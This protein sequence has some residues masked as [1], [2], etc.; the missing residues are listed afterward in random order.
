MKYKITTHRLRQGWPALTLAVLVALVY[1]PGRYGGYVFDDYPNIVENT[2]LHVTSLD[3]HAWIAAIFSFGVGILHRPLAMLTFAANYYFTGLDPVPMKLTNIAIH[4]VNA[5]LVLGLVRT[6]LATALPTLG[7]QRREWS[8]WFASAAWALHPINLM[9]VLFVVQRMESL[10]HTFVFAGLWLYL[11]G[12]QRQLDGKAGWTPIGLGILGGTALGVLVKESAVMLPLYAATVEICVLRF[13]NASGGGDRKLM[14]C[15]LLVLVLPAL[16]ALAWLL[17][18]AL[19]PTAYSTRDFTL[20]ERLLTEGRVVMDYLR[21]TVFPSLRQL[22]L[23]HDDFP[24]SRGLL[25]PWSTLPALLGLFAMLAFAFWLRLR[26]PLIALGMLWFL[27]AQLLTATFIP[28]ELVY[29]HRNYFASLG[30][31]LVSA[32]LLLIVPQSD[33]TRR[34]AAMLAVVWLLALA[35]TTNLRAREWSDPFRFA[36]SEVAK[37]PLSPRATY[38]NASLLIVATGFNP[39]SPLLHQA[40][41]AMEEAR[42][43]PRSG[44][45]PHSALLMLAA[46]T[47]QPVQHVWWNEMSTRLRANPVGIQEISA[48]ASLTRCA[49]EGRCE[50]PPAR[51]LAT[52]QA[53]LA[54]GPNPEILNIEADY[55]LNIMRQPQAALALWQDAIKLNPQEAQYRVN[56]IKLLIALGREQDARNEI[57]QLREL[58]RLG[59]NESTAR[60]LESRMASGH[61]KQ[62][63]RE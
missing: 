40:N 12:R 14:S 18:A 19:S 26:R 42:A 46:N 37:H 45:L 27:G 2:A 63:Q 53:A 41:D 7:Q 61:E 10:S 24:I 29:E 52:F 11:L 21:W 34:V 16:I 25:D 3:W 33:S 35:G 39:D 31:C 38:A 50:F 55:F 58:G 57:R 49:R 23:Y 8:A 17:P 5:C 60:Q 4:A 1:W 56:R 51:M 44:I 15:Y 32:D 22:S 47:G 13:R 62:A 9:A 20:H 36:R 43:A 54:H 48:I 6:L 59:Q 30:I 28:L